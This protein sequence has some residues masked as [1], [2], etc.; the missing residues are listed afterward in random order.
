MQGYEQKKYICYACCP[1]INE[2]FHRTAIS[3]IMRIS[4]I[5][6][7][8]DIFHFIFRPPKFDSSLATAGSVLLILSFI[9]LFVILIYSFMTFFK[10]GKNKNPDEDYVKTYIK[11]TLV[12]LGI[13]FLFILGMFIVVFLRIISFIE[14]YEYNLDT[15]WT[16]V[17]LVILFIC[18]LLT[19][20]EIYL[21]VMLMVE[22]E[23]PRT[24]APKKTKVI[25]STPV[26]TNTTANNNIEYQNEGYEDDFMG[27]NINGGKYI[28][29]STSQVSDQKDPQL[30]PKKVDAHQDDFFGPNMDKGDRDSDA[31]YYQ[32]DKPNNDLN[33]KGKD[34]DQPL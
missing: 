34:N 33:K 1:Q 2:K 32:T 20:W 29:D 23:K 17:L 24:Q 16:A 26:Y 28:G 10:Y 30:G 12:L 13:M 3:Y 5:T 4:I 22:G 15:E 9:L 21:L 31:Q 8:F 11:V 19:T 14:N 27:M 25:K 18:L 7:I 6:I